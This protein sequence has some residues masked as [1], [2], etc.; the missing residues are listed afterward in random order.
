MKFFIYQSL[1]VVLALAISQALAN[2]NLCSIEL[3]GLCQCLGYV[4]EPPFPSGQK[5]DG[6]QVECSYTTA[7]KLHHDIDKIFRYFNQTKPIYSLQV[8]NSDLAGL[9]GL[10]SGLVDIR[11]LVLD[12][13]AIDLEQVRESSEL[14]NGLKSLRVSNEN[15]TE[16]PESFF[17]GFHELSVL[18]LNDIGIRVI[19]E[20]GF[21]Y[22]E[23]SLKELRLRENKL[24]AIPISIASLNRLEIL[25]LENN[26]IT[27][28]P[29][30]QTALLESGLKSLNRLRMNRLNCTCD[31]GKTDFVAWLRSLAI[32]GATCSEPQQLNGR[33]ISTT[34]I[35]DFCTHTSSALSV[36]TSAFNL[37][38]CGVLIVSIS[39]VNLSICGVL[40]MIIVNHT[41]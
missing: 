18:E 11:H 30:D 6:L 10:P 3:K 13:T 8:R 4:V 2:T 32:K 12:N 39:A 29:D 15:L 14:L 19:S 28:I 27:S 26:E 24:K 22:L 20:D 38:V 36:N 37:S 33:D 9:R 21:T 17:Y 23:D 31:F 34:P 25:D 16:I 5:A 40:I 35:E 7:S 1:I 41:L